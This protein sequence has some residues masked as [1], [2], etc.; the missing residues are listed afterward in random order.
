MSEESAGAVVPPHLATFVQRHAVARL[1][2]VDARSRPHVVPICFALWG[3]RCYSPL[4]DKPKRV[5]HTALRRVRNVD[6][7]P[8]VCLVVDDYADDWSQLAW[9]QLRG[10]AALVEDP[11]ERDEA[12]RRLRAKYPQYQVMPLEERPLMRI[13]VRRVTAWRMTAAVGW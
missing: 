3:D 5:G 11:A 1:A 7:N 9:V 8:N 10:V 13:D 12:I 4:D 2:T 6:Q